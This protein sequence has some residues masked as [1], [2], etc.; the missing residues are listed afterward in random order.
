MVNRG[1]IWWA[2]LP[3][4]EKSQPGFR[5]PVVGVQADPFNHSRINT[6]ICAVVT[7]NLKLAAAPGNFM[8]SSAASGL[9]KDSVVN[10]SQIITVDKSFLTE[11]A[12]SLGYKNIIKLDD[13]LKLI[14]SIRS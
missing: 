5:R 2:D 1:E 3:E 12:G 9:P 4:P 10:I 8:L 14:F 11:K 13:G 6:V 7:S